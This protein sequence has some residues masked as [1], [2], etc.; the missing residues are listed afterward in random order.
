[1]ITLSIAP[2]MACKAQTGSVSFDVFPEKPAK[3]TWALASNPEENFKN[4]KLIS[5]P[6]EYDFAGVTVRG[7]GQEQGKHVSYACHTESMRVAFINTPVLE[8]TDAELEKLGDVDVLVVA[9][10]NPKKVTALVESVDPRVVVLF[11]VKSG[12][13]AGVAKA[14]GETTVE[15]VSEFKAKPGSLPQDTRHVVVLGK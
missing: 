4:K 1:M 14:L 8:W 6:G 5:W 13:M 2:G 15:P 12:D 10:D 7:V 9:A 3:D 11:S